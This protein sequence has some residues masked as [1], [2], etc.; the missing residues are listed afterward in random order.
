LY[1]HK[2]LSGDKVLNRLIKIEDKYSK[3]MSRFGEY[4]AIVITRKE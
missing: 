3:F 2:W 1:I 4:P